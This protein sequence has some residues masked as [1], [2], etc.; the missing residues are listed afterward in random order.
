VAIPTGLCSAWVETA[1][2]LDGDLSGLTEDQAD[3]VAMF[4]SEILYVLSNKYWP[5]VCERIVR[6]DLGDRRL[7]WRGGDPWGSSP[8]TDVPWWTASQIPY[9]ARWFA[10][11][12]H[13][14]RRFRLPGPVQSVD[15]IVING[16]PLDHNSYRVLDRNTLLRV[17]GHP[18]PT[19]QNLDHD[20][21]DPD[22]APTNGV[23]AW[24][25]A[26]EWG[27]EPP[28][29]AKLACA[30]LLRELVAALTGCA[31]CRLPWAG[32]VATVT[33][34]NTTINYAS[35][36]DKFPQGY[37]GLAD[38][39][40]WLNSVRGGPWRPRRPRIVRADARPRHS[41]SRWV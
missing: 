39:D 28:A 2:V 41:E 15:G 13:D 31:E 6:P 27:E 18:W 25:V 29:S 11:E 8:W 7:W 19:G 21:T 10:C 14:L 32:A 23:P 16:V 22:D 33:R 38:V 37:V 3:Q 36:L 34:K 30:S 40:L 4:A 26:Y 9:G 20:P 35:L 1:D 24:Q 17:D 12:A 5:G